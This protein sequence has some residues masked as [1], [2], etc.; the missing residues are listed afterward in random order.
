MKRRTILFTLILFLSFAVVSHANSD[1]CEIIPEEISSEFNLDNVDDKPESILTAFSF[2]NVANLIFDNIKD[3]FPLFIKLIAEILLILILLVIAQQLAQSSTLKIYQFI[4]S[5]LGSAILTLVLIHRFANACTLIENNLQT[6]KVF[7]NASIPI[8]TSFLI[9]T[10]KNFAATLFSYGISLSGSLIAVLTNDVCMPLLRIYIA[11][12][13]CGTIWTDLNFSALTDLIKKMIQWT[14]GVIF[15]VFTFTFS[16]Q[17]VLSRS[18]DN[19]ARKTLKTAAAGIPFLGSVLSQGMDGAF[20]LISGAKNSA[21]IIGVG[22][23][24]AMFIGPAI[25]IILQIFALRISQTLAQLFGAESCGLVLKTV[26]GAYELML[27]LFLVSV[28][29]S[30]ICFLMICVGAN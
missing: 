9:T 27:G 11:I 30:N 3:S 28:L 22:V 18:A 15:S 26:C 4:S 19:I 16:V 14:I 29:M 12:G 8:I 10:G 24:T 17:S 21:A 20:I 23:I 13:C 6:I 5:C 1:I 25:Q 7:C 2:A